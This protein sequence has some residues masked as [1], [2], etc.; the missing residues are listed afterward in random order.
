MAM[1]VKIAVI[2]KDGVV[3]KYICCCTSTGSGSNTVDINADT[4][5]PDG[6]THRVHMNVASSVRWTITRATANSRER[7][8]SSLMNLQLTVHLYMNTRDSSNDLVK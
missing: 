6:R 7:N 1:E 8:L 2:M 4:E 3:L 5:S